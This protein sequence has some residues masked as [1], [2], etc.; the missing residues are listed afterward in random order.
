MH[1][2]FLPVLFAGICHLFKVSQK[3]KWMKRMEMSFFFLISHKT[4]SAVPTPSEP[5]AENGICK[6]K[7]QGCWQDRNVTPAKW[8]PRGEAGNVSLLYP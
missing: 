8:A 3:L 4:L 2:F 6:P 1:G 7:T 5:V